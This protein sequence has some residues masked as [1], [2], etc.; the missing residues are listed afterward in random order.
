MR[1]KL[2][3]TVRANGRSNLAGE[4]IDVSDADGARLIETGWAVMAG[5]HQEAPKATEFET[6]S[7]AVD[8]SQDQKRKRGRPAK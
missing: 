1:I 6:E 4:E 2:V 7:V 5:V 8:Q 3:E